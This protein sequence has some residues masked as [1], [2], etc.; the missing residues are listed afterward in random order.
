MN[1][2]GLFARRRAAAATASLLGHMFKVILI[3]LVLFL[4]SQH[5]IAQEPTPLPIPIVSPQQQLSVP[6]IAVDYR[7]DITRPMPPLTRVGVDAAEQQ[8]LTLREAIAL[9]LQNN[10]DIEVA[11]DNVKIAEY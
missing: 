7:A 9:A 3:A 6:P 10:K 11:R 4:F 2:S 1:R 5:A 8:P